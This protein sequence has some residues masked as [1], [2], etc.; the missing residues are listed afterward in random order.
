[1]KPVP[2][3]PEDAAAGAALTESQ[4]KA[5]LL[6]VADFTEKHVAQN[7]DMLLPAVRLAF[8]GYIAMLRE[9]AR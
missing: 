1:M 8:A 7:S 9:S 2:F 4:F 3:I 6:H 5:A